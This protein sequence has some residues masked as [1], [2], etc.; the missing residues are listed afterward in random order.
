MKDDHQTAVS[1]LKHYGLE[2]TQVVP[3]GSGLINKTW[4]V[5]HQ[6]DRFILQRVNPMFPPEIHLDIEAVTS[7]LTSAGMVTPRL[8][9]THLG[10]LYCKDITGVW[11]LYNYLDGVTVDNVTDPGLASE[12]GLLLG[13]FHYVLQELDY[14]FRHV[15]PGVHDTAR[16][17]K[18]LNMA[19]ERNQGHPRYRDILSTATEIL[20]IAQTLP[21]LPVTITRKVHGD[22]KIN[23]FL[24]EEK[25][26]L[27]IC[28]LDFDTLSD[29]QLPL[30]L[31]DALRS[32]C[33]PVGENNPE[34]L[35]SLEN[36]SAGLEGYAA[37]SGGILSRDEWYAI[38]PATSII[39]IE[40][41][42]RFCADALN[43]DYF[44]W[45]PKR[46][47]SHSEHSQVRALG[48][49]NAYRS[50]EKQKSDAERIVDNTFVAGR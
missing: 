6:Q 23:N 50:L 48:Q 11:R 26:G 34:T 27:G 7:H 9:H 25:T 4:H 22:P 33:N 5:L 42:S 20:N 49:L 47:A 3:V 1:I 36:F 45:D 32:W 18:N 8:I 10:Q 16:H 39:Y 31:G 29:M 14:Q 44:A 37:N 30:E 43:E 38:L 13:Q 40:L 2:D 41:A 21:A 24:F 46:F 15:R 12:A 35:F 17:I 28:M 19:L